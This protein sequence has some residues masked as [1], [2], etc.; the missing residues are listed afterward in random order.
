MT[1]TTNDLFNQAMR[2]EVL[3]N[4][5]QTTLVSYR[6]TFV[7]SLDAVADLL[8]TTQSPHITPEDERCLDAAA[9]V[10]REAAHTLNVNLQSLG[11]RIPHLNPLRT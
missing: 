3:V 7:G 8:A 9:D 6:A 2:R 10:T 5:M 4:A 11:L 1:D